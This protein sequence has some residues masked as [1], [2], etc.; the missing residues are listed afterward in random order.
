MP[1]PVFVHLRLHT[2]FSLAD[3]LVTVKGL[4][5][6]VAAQGMA[7]VAVTDI[8][9]FFGLIKCYKALQ[10]V[11]VKPI[12]GADLCVWSQRWPRTKRGTRASHN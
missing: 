12:V 9:N 7:A 4:A 10:S 5:G 3:G 2:E 6:S 1:D 8:C 11:G